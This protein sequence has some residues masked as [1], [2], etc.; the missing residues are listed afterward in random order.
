MKRQASLP[1]VFPDE[2]RVRTDGIREHWL[3]YGYEGPGGLFPIGQ[4]QPPVRADVIAQC[5]ERREGK[6]EIMHLPTLC[7]VCGGI[8]ESCYVVGWHSRQ[9]CENCFAATAGR[10]EPQERPGYADFLKRLGG[11]QPDRI[12]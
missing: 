1:W 10:S 2:T 9:K 4:S 3:L 12:T 6:T 7:S 11:C 5:A 8:V